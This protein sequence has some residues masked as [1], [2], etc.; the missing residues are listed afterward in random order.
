MGA[1]LDCSIAGGVGFGGRA[2]GSAGRSG[3][4]TGTEHLG[5]LVEHR[6]SIGRPPRMRPK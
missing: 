1:D 4:S 3:R 5:T 6:R 2:M